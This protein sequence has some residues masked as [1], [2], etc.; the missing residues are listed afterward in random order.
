MRW[1]STAFLP[2]LLQYSPP[3]VRGKAGAAVEFGAKFDL[4][5]DSEGYGHIEK[6]SFE[7]RQGSLFWHASCTVLATADRRIY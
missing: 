3:V 6:I 1:R 7:A 5:L 2:V 4:S